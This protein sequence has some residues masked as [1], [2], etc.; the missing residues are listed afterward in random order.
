MLLLPPAYSAEYAGGSSTTTGGGPASRC[1]ITIVLALSSS[2]SSAF[3]RPAAVAVAAR[4]SGESL[5][6]VPRGAGNDKLRLGPDSS[7]AAARRAS[8]ASCAFRAAREPGRTG[9]VE[10]DV[11]ETHGGVGEVKVKGDGTV[12]LV[13]RGGMKIPGGAPSVNGVAASVAEDVD[14]EELVT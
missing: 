9:E 7:T 4:R 10:L 3:G 8:A 1:W 12:S 11:G 13:G 2:T 6:E 14:A 5:S